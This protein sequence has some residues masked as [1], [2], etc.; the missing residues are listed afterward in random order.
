MRFASLMFASAL[1]GSAATWSEELVDSRCYASATSNV[2]AD[3]AL[4][5][6]R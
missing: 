3:T 2:S 5:E 6:F 1:A 4:A